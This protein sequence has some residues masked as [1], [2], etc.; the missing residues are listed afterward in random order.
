MK[1]WHIYLIIS[2]VIIS[3]FFVISGSGEL[4][5]GMGFYILALGAVPLGIYRFI[6]SRK[7]TLSKNPVV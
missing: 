3:A 1:D 6:K 7:K 4:A 5:G 2:G